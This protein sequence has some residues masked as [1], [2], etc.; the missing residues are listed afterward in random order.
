MS[1]TRLVEFIRAGAPTHPAAQ[2]LRRR[3]LPRVLDYARLCCRDEWSAD[4][5]ADH[6]FALALLQIFRTHEPDAPW[7]HRLLT[8]VQE[9]AGEW[10]TGGSRDRLDPAYVAHLAEGNGGEPGHFPLVRGFSALPPA[11][12]TLLWHTLVE[13]EDDATVARCTG[14]RPAEIPR[15]VNR[16]RESYRETCLRLHLECDAD[17][18]CRGFGRILEAAIGRTDPLGTKNLPGHLT[19]C[20]GC[21]AV[22]SG[23]VGLE[24]R[25]RPLMAAALLGWAS[26][27]YLPD[28]PA[29]A[30]TVLVPVATGTAEPERSATPPPVPARRAFQRPLARAASLTVCSGVVM[31]AVITGIAAYAH[32]R[33]G[34]SGPG[35][36][37]A[38]SPTAPSLPPA[39]SSPSPSRSAGPTPSRTPP[40][41]PVTE[42]PS[43]I[44]TGPFMPIV[45][46][47]TGECLDV[48]GAFFN[49]ADVITTACRSDAATQEWRLDPDGLLRNRAEPGFCLDT[50]G[51]ISRGIGIRDCERTLDL[52][53]FFDERGRLRP[54][55]ASDH[56]IVPH[57]KAAGFLSFAPLTT[58][59]EQRWNTY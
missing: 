18:E 5:L 21:A 42:S 43:P 41:D 7:R 29:S 14:R 45:N 57:D 53:F 3:H 4:Q 52:L 58:D 12:R 35:R 50:R 2:E 56:A 27:R 51:R 32:E 40:S 9:A 26:D 33:S 1:D 37:Q 11:T 8:L 19:D 38:P 23:L 44:P 54:Q 59:T 16:A 10:A 34:G 31:A 39:T 22:L 36:A 17:E 48:Q 15:L 20:P 25:P 46:A 28:T 30:T 47:A 24:K 6:A 49:D 13:R 55:L